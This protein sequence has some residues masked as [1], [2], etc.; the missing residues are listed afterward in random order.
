MPRYAELQIAEA[1]R[2][3]EHVDR[4]VPDL[5][6]DRLPGLFE[7]LLEAQLPLTSA[8]HVRLVSFRHTFTMLCEELGARG[9]PQSIQHDDL[10]MNNVYE[11][12]GAIRVLDWGDASIGHPF[13]S[14][15]ETFR[16]LAESNHLRPGNEWFTLLRDAYLEPWG[17]D[18]EAAFDLA[19]RVGAVAHAIAWLH[20]RAL[21]P[22]ADRPS[23]DTGFAHI[24]R[25]TLGAATPTS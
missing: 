11:R 17:S 12:D 10:H 20:Q 8:E 3:D 24:L 5:R 23:F 2:A 25:L 19:L 13:F 14:L 18:H 6:L 9:I 21:L 4:G 7:E 15:F 16:F 1:E 22:A